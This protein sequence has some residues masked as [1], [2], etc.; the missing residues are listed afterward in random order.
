CARDWN[1]WR[2]YLGWFDVW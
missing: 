2:S 1:F